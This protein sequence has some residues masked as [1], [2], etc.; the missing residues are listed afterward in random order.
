M[1]IEIIFRLADIANFDHL[2]GFQI[3]VPLIFFLLS[4]LLPEKE[5]T[6]RPGFFLFVADFDVLIFTLLFNR[7]LLFYRGGGH[8]FKSRHDLPRRFLDNRHFLRDR[9]FSY[10]PRVVVGGVVS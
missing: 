5:V 10:N 4:L 1:Y 8:K 6:S 7:K 3:Y 9:L 2:V